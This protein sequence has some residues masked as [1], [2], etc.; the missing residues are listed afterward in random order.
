MNTSG[1]EYYFD[2][3]KF[4]GEPVYLGE[5][6]TDE[7]GRLLFLGGHGISGTPFANNPPTTFANNNGWHDD[8]SDGPVDAEVIYE[9][10]SLAVEG[11]WVVCA[12]PN[13]APDIISVQTLYDVIVDALNNLYIPVKAQPSFM[14]DIY[15]LLQQLSSILSALYSGLKAGKAVIG[16]FAGD[17]EALLQYDISILRLYTQFL[18]DRRHYYGTEQRW[19]KTLFWQTRREP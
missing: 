3:G 13:Y 19:P 12:P 10:R 1:T 11:A 16:A 15:P 18:Q 5:L 8:V 14:E 7:Q 9:G 4:I 17:R 6:R 2:K